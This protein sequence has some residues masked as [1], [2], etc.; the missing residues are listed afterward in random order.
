MPEVILF[1]FFCEEERAVKWS[2]RGKAT[3]AGRN[4]STKSGC[5]STAVAVEINS[6][7][8][9]DGAFP[10]SRGPFASASREDGAVTYAMVEIV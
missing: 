2:R 5:F 3:V 7:L 1:I 9:H 6:A 10:A 8:L 4:A